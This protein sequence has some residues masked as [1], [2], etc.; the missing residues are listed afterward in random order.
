MV[1]NLVFGLVLSKS[2]VNKTIS[3]HQTPSDMVYITIYYHFMAK[4][5]LK[6]RDHTLVYS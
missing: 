2:M 3:D 5:R 1:D 6:A 4:L